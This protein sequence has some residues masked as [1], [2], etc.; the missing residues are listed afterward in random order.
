MEVVIID[1]TRDFDS[2]LK[3]QSRLINSLQA[4]A[5]SVQDY[6]A[7]KP[8]RDR[9]LLPAKQYLT[10]KLDNSMSNDRRN[11]ANW[12]PE[13]IEQLAEVHSRIMTIVDEVPDD[14]D[15]ARWYLVRIMKAYKDTSKLEFRDEPKVVVDEQ[16][17]DDVLTM[18]SDL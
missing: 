18:L 13:F 15:E 17:L 8:E 5:D 3:A 14:L 11:F 4:S 10:D 2:D 7:S 16:M 12:H 6:I 9:E 1:P